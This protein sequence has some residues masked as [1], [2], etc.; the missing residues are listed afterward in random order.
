MQSLRYGIPLT[1]RVCCIWSHKVIILYLLINSLVKLI[2][3]RNSI[4]FIAVVLKKRCVF[5]HHLFNFYLLSSI[6]VTSIGWRDLVMLWM[7]RVWVIL[8]SLCDRIMLNCDSLEIW[9]NGISLRTI[10]L[11]SDSYSWS[12]AMSS[13]SY[14]EFLSI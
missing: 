13:S 3:V 7:L 5:D 12:W 9:T 8:T 14:S 10:A 2:L 6:W 4:N 11:Y 1:L